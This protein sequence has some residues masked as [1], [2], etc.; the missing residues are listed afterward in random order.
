MQVLDIMTTEIEVV[1]PDCSLREVAQKMRDFDF[2][3]MPVC[4][5]TRILG[6]ITDRDLVLRAI[7]E[8]KA[9]DSP[10]R[11][12]L[13][14]PVFW[15]YE[16]LDLEEAH[17]KMK[18]EKIRRLIVLNRNKKLVGILSLGDLASR[19]DDVAVGE[20][21]AKISQPSTIPH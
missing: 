13:Q 7:A 9:G 6:L 2:G 19:Q 18:K 5:G 11:E 10:V 17:E 21:L 16:D 4:D 8:G 15:V 14:G 20:T 12:V 3:A 1:D